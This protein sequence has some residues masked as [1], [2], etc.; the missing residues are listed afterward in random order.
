MSSSHRSSS[1]E[2]Q[3]AAAGKN[4]RLGS[5]RRSAAAKMKMTEGSP[6]EAPLASLELVPVFFKPHHAYICTCMREGEARKSKRTNE[7]TLGRG[8][9][10]VGNTYSMMSTTGFNRVVKHSSKH[11]PVAHK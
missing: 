4:E 3:V 1:N 8:V 7:C 6:G 10:K 9:G 2:L 5:V 11:R